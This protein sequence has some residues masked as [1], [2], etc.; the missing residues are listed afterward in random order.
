MNGENLREGRSGA[1][2]AAPLEG[3]QEV[4]EDIAESGSVLE[5]LNR[6]EEFSRKSEIP[7][8]K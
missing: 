8:V 4:L 1:E 2:K 7:A 3:A 5:A 6:G